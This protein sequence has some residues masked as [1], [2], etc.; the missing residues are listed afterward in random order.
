MIDLNTATPAKIDGVLAEIYK[1]GYAAEADTMTAAGYVKSYRRGLA[2][3]IERYGKPL[4]SSED[5]LADLI[6]AVFA[7]RVAAFEI[8]VE[9][10]PY[11][12]EFERR[13]GWTR[14]FL[15]DNPGGHVHNSMSCDTCFPTTQFVWLPEFSGQ[16]EAGV[17]E[18]AGESAC[19][20]CFPSAPVDVLKRASRIEA[21]D[22]KAAR[23]EREAAKAKRDAAKA[24]KAIAHPDGS[25]LAVF[26]YHVE[27][28]TRQLRGGGEE[29]IPA[30][31]RYETLPT[32]HSARGWL[33]DRFDSWRSSTAR[34]EDVD[35][36]AAAVA[37]KEGK[38]AEQ[39]IAEAR[40][41]AAN[42]T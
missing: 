31:D 26:D 27:E 16:G 24:A 36:V 34:Q 23:L 38:T 29:I 37:A 1:R 7:R 6:V 4:Y 21:P 18:L 33:A 12:A 9:T 22:R 2:Q 28:R 3:E 11:E 14:F 17:V 15:V 13:G 42:R 25:P 8:W 19:S 5:K 39:V 32:L 20:R 10:K 35:R 41:R 30:H 40:K